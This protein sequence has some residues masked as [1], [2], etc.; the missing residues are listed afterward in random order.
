MGI[1]RQRIH[2]SSM[3]ILRLPPI[4]K[5]HR[6]LCMHPAGERIKIPFFQ[7]NQSIIIAIYLMWHEPPPETVSI[8]RLQ[9]KLPSWLERLMYLLENFLV[10]LFAFQIAEGGEHIVDCIECILEGD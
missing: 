10:F 8:H 7:D 3:V 5:E 1:F 6:H 2:T 4:G 9:Q